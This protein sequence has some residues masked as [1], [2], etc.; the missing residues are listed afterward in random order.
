MRDLVIAAVLGAGMGAVA[1]CVAFLIAS[2]G[3][4]RHYEM[5]DWRDMRRE[6]SAA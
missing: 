5:A 1:A 4:D 3:T 2:A 6:R